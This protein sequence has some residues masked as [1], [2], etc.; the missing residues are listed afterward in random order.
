MKIRSIWFACIVGVAAALSPGLSSIWELEAAADDDSDSAAPVPQRLEIRFGIE[1]ANQVTLWKVKSP[2]GLGYY[3]LRAWSISEPQGQPPVETDVTGQATWVSSSPAVGG[4]SSPPGFFRGTDFAGG[5]T[6]V[7]A[8]YGSLVSG[9]FFITLPH[10]MDFPGVAGTPNCAGVPAIQPHPGLISGVSAIVGALRG[11]G[12][13]PIDP[14]PPA[15]PPSWDPT[16][17]WHQ[18]L[19]V[20]EGS[21]AGGVGAWHP[22]G[23]SVYLPG[24]SVD[25][26]PN[27]NGGANGD[28]VYLR[29]N[30]G[31]AVVG[32]DAASAYRLG[33]LVNQS[34][35][36]I[37][38]PDLSFYD[39]LAV[40][41][42]AWCREEP[43][44]D[45]G[46]S[47]SCDPG[48]TPGGQVCQW[49]SPIYVFAG[50]AGY[51]EDGP[52]D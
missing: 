2:W 29:S 47:C 50:N 14:I 13:W 4:F 7:T 39:M 8:S 51:G 31:S 22:N 27:N 18:F 6:I 36:L 43:D 24:I 9:E 32:V 41:W 45:G 52:S 37:F 12:A 1:C 28:I 25:E 3:Q 20:E 49:P 30:R 48:T 35:G 26:H 5:T 42:C 40:I 17:P 44:C 16:H 34:G 38:P 19:I 11:I 15:L 33:E 10:N 46:V 21:S 23:V